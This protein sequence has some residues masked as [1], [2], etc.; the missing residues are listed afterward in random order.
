MGKDLGSHVEAFESL[1]VDSHR[2]SEVCG[3]CLCSKPN[4]DCI[5]SDHIVISRHI[6]VQE[7]GPN[8]SLELS[9]GSDDE[10]QPQYPLDL[11]TDAPPRPTSDAGVK[12][13]LGQH[14]LH[15]V[16]ASQTPHPSWDQPGASVS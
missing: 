10:A 16:T 9:S 6:L 14:T 8:E 1:W 15:V 11:D 13:L 3:F 2:R 12:C 5:K 4:L 7:G